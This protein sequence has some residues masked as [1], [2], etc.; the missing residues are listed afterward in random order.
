VEYGER[1][2]QRA[3]AVFAY[4]E[5]ARHLEQALKVQQV[6]DTGDHARRCDLLL[7]LGD[8]LLP[9]GE[10]QRVFESVSPEALSLAESLG[11]S[12]RAF[13]ASHLGAVALHQHGGL[14]A[15]MGP[16][17]KR[18]A[19]LADR[20]AAPGTIERVWADRLSMIRGRGGNNHPRLLAQRGVKLA[21]ELG[22][23]SALACAAAPLLS[24]QFTPP[25]HHANDSPPRNSSM[26]THSTE[27][28]RAID[29]SSSRTWVMSP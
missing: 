1:A 24:G 18:W 9:A 25:E 22:D 14:V 27:S 4:G 3:T 29:F 8:A 21:H 15:L 23:Q 11:D 26:E 28:R 16:E 12:P 20:Y 13:R 6:L 7:A 17:Y 2:A 5:A 19:D 10:P